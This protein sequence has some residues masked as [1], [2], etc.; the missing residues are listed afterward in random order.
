MKWTLTS[1]L[2]A[3]LATGAPTL[4]QVT[5]SEDFDDGA[6]STRWSA[7]I[8]D[9]E[10]GAFDG[11]VDYAFDYSTVG[12]PAAP[13]GATTTGVLFEVNRTDNGGD[14]G[15]SVAILPEIAAGD[16]PA[17]SFRVSYD[18]YFVVETTNGGS[19]E[20]GLLGVH[21]AAP[22]AP[23]DQGLN[24]DV[25]FDLG[26]SNGNGLAWKV[27]GDGGAFNDFHRFEDAGN[28]DAGSQTGLGG[29]DALV[30]G[31]I[32]G[33]T[34]PIGDGP[35]GTWVKL[36]IERVG[37]NVSVSINGYVFDTIQDLSGDYT[38]GTILVGYSDPFNS[39]GVTTYEVG[40]DP[41][42]LDDSDGPFG[43][44]IPGY[45]HFLVVD[46]VVIESIIPEPTSAVLGFL[47]LAG[48]AVQRRR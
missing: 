34:G 14:Q 6:A 48:L 9:A 12:I 25:P 31:T 11:T 20:F 43:D 23:A 8:V 39:V 40:P 33:L 7:P 10:N 24:D 3:A 47:A 17:G 16:L 18:A 4:A 29:F 28:A 37:V 19:T 38:D 27:S 45:A 2:L 36:A 35:Q 30:E 26:V 44:A 21:T 5:F 41:T 42:P 46:N 22:N 15:E 32:P 1:A 13:G